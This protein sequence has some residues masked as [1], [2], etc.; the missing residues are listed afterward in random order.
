MGGLYGV[1]VEG[2]TPPEQKRQGKALRTMERALNEQLASV[3]GQAWRAL[4]GE[5][6]IEIARK[7]KDAARR[8][9]M[10]GILCQ[11][12]AYLSRYPILVSHR[13]PV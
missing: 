7:E 2:I 9:R 1:S 6:A 12:E 3:D 8:I 4:Y 5:D 10:L 11:S 13:N